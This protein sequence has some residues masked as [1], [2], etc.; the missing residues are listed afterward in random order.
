MGP[1]PPPPG[2]FGVKKVGVGVKKKI[3]F[4]LSS[5]YY[6]ENI[7]PTFDIYRNQCYDIYM[8]ILYKVL[9]RALSVL[10]VHISKFAIFIQPS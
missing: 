2:I 6:N 7:S 5:F 10:F 1:G 3:F 8:L 4:L 9:K